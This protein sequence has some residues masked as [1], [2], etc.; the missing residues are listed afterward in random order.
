VSLLSQRERTRAGLEAALLAKGHPEAEVRDALERVA[1]L[2]YLD[3]AKVA[4]ARARRE[5]AQGRSRADV[6]RRLVAHGVDEALAVAATNE[7]AEDVAQDDETAARKLV[8]Q[9]RLTGAKAA[10]LLAARGFDEAL[11]RKVT[12]LHDE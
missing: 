1:R 10:R 4:K 8:A 3:D 9:R 12:G 6:A 2:G 7:V 5:L 11:I